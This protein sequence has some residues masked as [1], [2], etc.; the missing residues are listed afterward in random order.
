MKCDDP[1]RIVLKNNNQRS[2]VNDRK[3]TIAS[4]RSQVNDLM[5]RR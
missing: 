5:L 2:Q 3:S 1:K 4:K